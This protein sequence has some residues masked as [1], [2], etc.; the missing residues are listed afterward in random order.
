VS[1]NQAL[2]M[3]DPETQQ[4]NLENLKVLLFD[5]NIRQKFY[6]VIAG[7]YNFFGATRTSEAFLNSFSE[8]YASK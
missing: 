3:F 7:K 6:K 8:S 5:R 4:F 2:P 1:L